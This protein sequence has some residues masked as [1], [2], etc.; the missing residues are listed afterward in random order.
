MF[1]IGYKT[2]DRRP[3]IDHTATEG[4]DDNRET[5]SGVNNPQEPWDEG[6]FDDFNDPSVDPPDFRRIDEPFGEFFQGGGAFD[7][8]WEEENIRVV[9]DHDG[10]EINME[11]PPRDG[12]VDDD[13]ELP[14]PFAQHEGP[15]GD[16]E[17]DHEDDDNGY[18]SDLEVLRQALNAL[19]LDLR[20]LQ[21]NGLRNSHS[22]GGGQTPQEGDH[23]SDMDDLE[24]HQNAET[25][26]GKL[27]FSRIVSSKFFEGAARIYGKG[28]TFLE[29][30]S[31]D[32][33]S[34]ARINQ[35][36][37]YLPWASHKEWEFANVLS[38]MHCSLEEKNA[39]LNTQVVSSP[40]SSPITMSHLRWLLL[41]PR[42]GSLVQNCPSCKPANRYPTAWA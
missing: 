13:D 3:C 17:G 4:G 30:F 16:V 10:D 9:I 36:N 34:D 21:E 25:R 27:P 18:E 19:G 11:D 8:E 32:R 40:P 2:A 5:L 41:A 22:A 33:L 23:V 39:L 14:N 20:Y 24:Q 1:W 7:Q 31:S 28:S 12:D 6:Q 37:I 15:D 29:K 38:R 42:S 26:Q 35:D